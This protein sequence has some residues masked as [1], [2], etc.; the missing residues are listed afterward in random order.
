M[1]TIEDF[2]KPTQKQLFKMLADKFKG[3]TVNNDNYILVE[4]NAPLLLVAHLDTVHKEQ[5]R[6][7]CKS[8]SGNILMSPQGIGGDDRCG[9]YALTSI[10][11]QAKI[12]PWLLFTCNEEIGG[13]G[14]EAFA[15]DFMQ[16]IL[17]AGLADLKAIVEID[18]KG[19]NDAVYYDC[20]NYDFENYITEKGFST[21]FGSFSDIS[22]IAPVL[23][24]AAVNLSSG[25]YYAHTLYE[26]I[27]KK[28]LEATIQRVLEIVNDASK[29][30]FPKY[31]YFSYEWEDWGYGNYDLCDTP[32]DLPKKY[33]NLYCELLDST[34][35][36]K[37]YV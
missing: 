34:F 21:A 9:V 33:K 16:G 26:Y 27:N 31:E 10:Y 1:K 13:V 6:V 3:S 30:D 22:I 28:H 29:D 25:Y 12:K 8:N 23:G 35:P 37:K 14:A 17:P 18:R 32:K 7:I 4:G 11:E 15:E 2:L 20:V 24:I 19:K 36:S 5:V